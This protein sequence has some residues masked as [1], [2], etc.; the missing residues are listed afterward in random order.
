MSFLNKDD[1]GWERYEQ[2]WDLIK[3]KLGIKFHSLPIYE[4]N[5]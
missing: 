5:T 3:N 2:I 1:E 4:K